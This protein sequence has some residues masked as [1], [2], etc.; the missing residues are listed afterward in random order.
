M[1][2]G[3]TISHIGDVS[4]RDR[5]NVEAH[6]VGFKYEYWGIFWINLWTWNGE[7]CIY[8]GD[9][10]SPIQR[11]EAARLLGKTENELGAPFLYHFPLGWFIFGPLIVIGI[12]ASRM[13][14]AKRRGNVPL[15][16]DPNYRKALEIVRDKMV[17]PPAG[18][19]AP[20]GNEGNPTPAAE[21]RFQTSFEAGVQFLLSVGI[22][23]DDAELNLA[24]MIRALQSAAQ[25]QAAAASGGT[26]ACPKCCATQPLGSQVCSCGEPLQKD[27][28]K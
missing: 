4:A 10:F 1:T 3:E 26:I 7:Y 12:I 8:E 22:P 11:S 28:Q 6:K 2:S 23:R 9:R 15:F 20:E 27:E 13:E 18:N 16:E 19:T 17:N 24:T 21:S 5:Q 25:Q 14:K